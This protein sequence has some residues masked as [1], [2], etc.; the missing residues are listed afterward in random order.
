MKRDRGNKFNKGKKAMSKS[1]LREG[2]IN[3]KI[4]KIKAQRKPYKN[5]KTISLY[6]L[7]AKLN[8]FYFRFIGRF[9]NFFFF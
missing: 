4:L 7:E 6:G 3:I 8:S 9:G 5:K 2:L 1:L